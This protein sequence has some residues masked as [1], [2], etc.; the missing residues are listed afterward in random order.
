MKQFWTMKSGKALYAVI[1][2]L[3]MFEFQLFSYLEGSVNGVLSKG[4]YITYALLSA[5]FIL[6]GASRILIREEKGRQLFLI[7]MNTLFA[8]AVLGILFPTDLLPAYVLT[9]PAALTL[10]CLG[11]AVYYF[12]ALEF[13]M[14]KRAGVI[15]GICASVPYILQFIMTPFLHGRFFNVVLLLLL[16]G[17]I[18]Y[19]V[20]AHP[21]DYIL[22]NPLPYSEETEEYRKD[23]FRDKYHILS[24]FFLTMLLGVCMEQSWS[25]ASGVD[26]YGWQRLCAIPGYFFIGVFADHKKH[27]HMDIAML[28]SYA[29]FLLGVYDPGS[30]GLSLA[31]FYF[32]AGVYTG[33]LNLAFWFLAPRTRHPEIWA[34]LGR[35]L[36]LFEGVIG[37]GF[38][39]VQ[40]GG[41]IERLIIGV[42]ILC[43][44]ILLYRERTKAGDEAS[45]SKDTGEAEDIFD[46]FGDFCDLHGYTPRERDVM[47]LLLRSDESMKNISAA[48]GISERMLY[49]Y[50]NSLY[51]KTGTENRAGLVKKYYEE[52][53]AGNGSIGS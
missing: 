30:C 19:F 7:I 45:V 48:L 49:R 51:E 23:L 3:Y 37:I 1:F 33:Y 17:A 35:T 53:S 52:R 38:Y 21:K 10:G 2:S 8:L 12:A 36:S 22:Q 46:H 5:G 42:I 20:I 44:F 34:G 29:F 11:G 16:T 4:H 47:N 18:A 41:L 14:S 9:Y 28:C 25:G 32:L 43:M 40:R 31:V 15:M 6:F 24:V 26:M 13:H 39:H 27:K 50:M